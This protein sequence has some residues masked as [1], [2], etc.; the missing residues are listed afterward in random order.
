[1]KLYIKNTYVQDKPGL[2]VY[3]DN[4]NMKYS[5]PIEYSVLGMKMDIYNFNLKRISKIRQRGFSFNKTYNITAGNKKIKLIL[6]VEENNVSAFIKG[7]PFIIYGDFI[8]K[9][10]TIVNEN[11][12][13][14]MI[15]KCNHSIYNYYELD[16]KLKEY[17]LLCLC[18]ALC[19]D[20]LLFFDERG[21]E[22]SNISLA[23]YI[24][25][26]KKMLGGLQETFSVNKL[27]NNTECKILKED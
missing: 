2:I 19:I 10:F 6:K 22:K 12:L 9:E 26:N 17:E 14:V 3:D 13:I 27:K 7:S 23:K 24:I 20:T 1:M 11:K 5:V 15:Q 18:I 8:K 16:I 4:E 25:E 21:I